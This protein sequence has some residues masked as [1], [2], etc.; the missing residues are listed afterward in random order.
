MTV[1]P[2]FAL[3]ARALI[4][5]AALSIFTV[6]APATA[7]DATAAESAK[8]RVEDRAAVASCLDRVAQAAK[9]QAEA[10][11]KA[12]DDDDGE[13]KPEK[14]DPADWLA[15]AGERAAVDPASCVGVVSTPCQ[16]TFEGRSNAGSA[17]CVRRE[18]AV[19]DERLNRKLR[20]V[21]PRLWRREGVRR[22]PQAG[23]GVA[24]RPR[25][26]LRVAVDRDAGDDGQSDD[27][28]LP[29]RRDRPPGDL[30][31]ER[32]AV[33]P[34]SFDLVLR[35]VSLTRCCGWGR[36]RGWAIAKTPLQ[37]P[38][39]DGSRTAGSVQAIA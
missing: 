28:R 21:D 25:C 38:S 37:R 27:E 23:A 24:R 35:R 32:H 11:A 6:I 33:T 16:Q 17:D 1:R 4:L 14:I 2:R 31:R 22:P 20:A 15:H 8:P 34:K 29:A 3:S 7:L 18:L 12:Q 13:P 9:R 19:W 10:L 30:A 36:I 39:T 5:G 26:P